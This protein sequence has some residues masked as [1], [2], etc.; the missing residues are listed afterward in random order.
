MFFKHTKVLKKSHV[1]LLTLPSHNHSGWW[2][3]FFL[4]DS[5]RPCREP[6]TQGAEPGEETGEL[7]AGGCSDH[8][9]STNDDNAQKTKLVFYLKIFNQTTKASR[10]THEAGTAMQQLQR[11]FSSEGSLRM[12]TKS[13]AP[14]PKDFPQ[15][16]DL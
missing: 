7:P 14:L 11:T 1:F 8:A 10:G 5:Q 15:T 2:G 12:V 9:W 6:I 16:A 3:R 4:P 13:L